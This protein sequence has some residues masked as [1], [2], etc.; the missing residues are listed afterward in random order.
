[1]TTATT[2]LSPLPLRD[3][4]SDDDP[5]EGLDQLELYE[6][7]GYAQDLTASDSPIPYWIAKLYIWP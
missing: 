6:R 4:W 3:E 7:E 1:V 5:D 2:P